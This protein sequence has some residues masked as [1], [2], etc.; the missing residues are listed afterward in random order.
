MHRMPSSALIMR[1]IAVLDK[2]IGMAELAARLKV[3]EDTL[4]AWRNGHATMPERKFLVLVDILTEHVPSWDT[5]DETA[6]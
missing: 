4:R 3:P 6:G 5:W 1:V 2:K